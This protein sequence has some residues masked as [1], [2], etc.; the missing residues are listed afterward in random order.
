M[1]EWIRPGFTDQRVI[2]ERNNREDIDVLVV[3][4]EKIKQDLS[5]L[6][7]ENTVLRKLI[8]KGVNQ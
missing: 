7:R 2:A 3:E 8:L 1:S 6:K 4:V 5:Y